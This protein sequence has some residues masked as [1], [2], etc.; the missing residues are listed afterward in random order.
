MQ[1]AS[2]GLVS[3]GVHKIHLCDDAMGRHWSYQ[4]PDDHHPLGAVAQ[5]DRLQQL[6]VTIFGDCHIARITSTD[7]TIHVPP[8]ET[9][10]VNKAQILGE[11]TGRCG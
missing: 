10:Q 9:G 8:R 2:F 5:D 3:G 6:W 11:T 4:P 7:F 1:P